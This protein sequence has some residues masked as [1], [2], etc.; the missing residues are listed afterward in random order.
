[1]ELC[2][3]FSEE[4]S[5]EMWCSAKGYIKCKKSDAM[6]LLVIEYRIYNI[7]DVQFMLFCIVSKR[8]SRKYNTKMMRFFA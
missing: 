4:N 5:N 2:C 3:N 6:T 1:M 8:S 7:C